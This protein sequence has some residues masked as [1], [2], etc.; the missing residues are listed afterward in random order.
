MRLLQRTADRL[1][2]RRSILPA[3]H[4][5]DFIP[6]ELVIIPKKSGCREIVMPGEYY[7]AEWFRK[8]VLATAENRKREKK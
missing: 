5:L 4:G 1:V 3:R 7:R 6:K 2:Q 8:A